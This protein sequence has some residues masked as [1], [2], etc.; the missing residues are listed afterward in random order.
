MLSR[1]PSPFFLLPT[2]GA[3]T[4]LTR[5]QSTFGSQAQCMK[6]ISSEHITGG[7]CRLPFEPEGDARDSHRIPV[8]ERGPTQCR[9]TTPLGTCG[10]AGTDEPPTARRAPLLSQGW[11]TPQSSVCCVF[12]HTYERLPHHARG[13]NRRTP[14]HE[15]GR[16]RRVATSCWFGGFSRAH[17]PPQ[18]WVH[19]AV[20]PSFWRFSLS[21]F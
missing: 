18:A 9:R 1:R 2:V 16:Q 11:D 7:L 5:V 21:P 20:S 3:R 12:T 15:L 14:R 13:L 4:P 6:A 8:S 10:F 19:D 17:F